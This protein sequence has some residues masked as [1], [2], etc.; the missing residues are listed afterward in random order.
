MRILSGLWQT[1]RAFRSDAQGVAA[2]EF[3]L[4][5]PIMLLVYAGSVEATAL[6][7]I[8][9]RVQTVASTLGDLVSRANKQIGGCDLNTLFLASSGIMAPYTTDSLMQVVSGL[10]VKS[11]GSSTVKWSVSYGP[12][13]VSRQAGTSFVLPQAMR[14]IARGN[15][16]VVAEASYTYQPMTRVVYE[17][18]IPL[19]RENFF[20][21]RFPNPITY[22]PANLS[23]CS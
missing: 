20:L 12:G 10:E 21:P 23:A 5:F 9:R 11:D 17:M 6:L 15:F 7:S 8:D 19:R 2:I 4:I 1:F 22:V 16:V 13:S 14:D 18:G 3:A